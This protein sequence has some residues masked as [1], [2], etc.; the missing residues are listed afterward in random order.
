[1]AWTFRKPY[2][3]K[4]SSILLHSE[5]PPQPR[6]KE[7]LFHPITSRF[8]RQHPPQARTVLPQHPC[9]H[10]QHQLQDRQIIL[11]PKRTIPSPLLTWEPIHLYPIQLR[12]RIHTHPSSQELTG[13]GD[14][15][16]LEDMT[17]THT[18]TQCSPQ[19]PHPRQRVLP[20]HAEIHPQVQR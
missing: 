11:R 9:C 15:C 13:P 10:H 19:S 8:P 17:R 7:S 4:S 20:H 6:A 12:H 1:M 5:R 14:Q 3:Q 2:L 16:I 18:T